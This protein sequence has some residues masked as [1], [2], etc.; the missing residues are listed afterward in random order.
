MA[1]KR[2][3]DKVETTRNAIFGVIIAI[4]VALVGLGIYLSSGLAQN[5]T[6][7]EGE[8]YALIENADRIRIGDPIN[9]YEFFSYG[10]V[11]CRNFDPELE[12]W[13]VTTEEDVAFSRKPAAF[14]R[15]WTLLGQGYL[16]LEQADA[17]EGNHAKLFSAVHDFGKTFRSGQEIADYLDSETLP[18][19]EF[20]RAFNSPKVRR[21]L[22]QAETDS[23]RYNVQSVPTMIVAGKYAVDMG[24][25]MQR[26]LE[27]V[28]YLI[29]Q[30]RTE[31]GGGVATAQ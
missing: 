18:A 14:S 24:N 8:D 23:R 16:A 9:V 12:E 4:G 19:A 17:L 7:T 29:G 21:K 5:A 25:G 1:K 27:V 30:E 10:C 26:A 6:P 20:M 2:G 15:T 3:T 11:H 13:L 28:D 22:S 31:R